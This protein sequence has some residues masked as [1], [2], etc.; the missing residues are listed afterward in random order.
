VPGG[1]TVVGSVVGSLR[2]A[3]DVPRY[4][5][6]YEQGVLDLDALVTRRYDLAA[7]SRAFEDLEAGVGVRGVVTCDEG[8]RADRGPV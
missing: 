1:K 6:L 3:E 5:R 2:P 7:L 4:A 8:V